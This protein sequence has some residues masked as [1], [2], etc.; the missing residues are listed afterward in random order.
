MELDVRR[1]ANVISSTLPDAAKLMERANAN[2][3]T[4]VKPANQVSEIKC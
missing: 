3:D 2:L 1:S 4:L